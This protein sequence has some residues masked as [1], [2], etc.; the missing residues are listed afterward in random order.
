MKKHDSEEN[1]KSMMR[2]ILCTSAKG[3]EETWKIGKSTEI[4]GGKFQFERLRS[5]RANLE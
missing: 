5:R 3:A 4:D 1:K 2:S